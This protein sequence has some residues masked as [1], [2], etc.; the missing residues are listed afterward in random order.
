MANS[1]LTHLKHSYYICIQNYLDF[2]MKYL[3]FYNT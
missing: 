2:I 1:I 3:K